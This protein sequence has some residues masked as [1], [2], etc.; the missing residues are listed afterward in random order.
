LKIVTGGLIENHILDY[1]ST[2]LADWPARFVTI[3]EEIPE[4]AIVKLSEGAKK[5]ITVNAYGRNK[6]ARKQCLQNYGFI[7]SVCDF[8]FEV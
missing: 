3:A 7:C 4:K 5:Q 1:S 2:V 6:R 8:D